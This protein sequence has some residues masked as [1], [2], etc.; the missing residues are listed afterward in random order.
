MLKPLLLGIAITLAGN[1]LLAQGPLPRPC[2]HGNQE[3]NAER[4]RRTQA[5]DYVTKVNIAESARLPA[6]PRTYRPLPELGNIPPVPAG[7]AVQFHN[8]D[9]SYTVSLKDTRDA[10][11]YAVFSDQDRLVYEGVP[12]SDPG[13]IV[14]LGTR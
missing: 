9:R 2:L 14:P 10:C 5:I 1:P 11:H 13:G 7:F 4:T 6:L 8:D 3:S 12:R